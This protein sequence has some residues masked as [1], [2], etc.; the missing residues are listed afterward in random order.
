MVINTDARSAKAWWKA[1]ATTSLLA[2]GL[3]SF[4]SPTWAQ[5][6]VRFAT[7][8]PETSPLI[9]EVYRPWAEEINEAADGEFEIQILGP[10]FANTANVVDRVVTGVAEMGI[11]VLPATGQPFPRSTVTTLPLV[12]GDPARAS[13][14]LWKLQEKGLLGD[15]F[16][17]GK[18]LLFG[19]LASNTLR[20]REPITSLESLAGL[21]VRVSDKNTA[22]AMSAL[23]ASPAFISPTEMYQAASRGVVDAV[24][25]SPDTFQSFRLTELLHQHLVNVTFGGVPTAVVINK[26]FYEGLSPKGRAVLDSFTGE[27]GTRRLGQAYADFIDG[28]TASSANEPQ[29]S[30][31]RFDEAELEKVRDLISPVIESWIER[32]PDGQTVLDAFKAE[33]AAA[34]D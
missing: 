32:T 31:S 29:Y 6:V 7:T 1:K 24:I 18:L 26:S 8:L 28:I 27:D 33:Y 2:L 9:E 11:W 17:E 3:A 34:S 12:G 19:V 4:G 21:K 25:T 15:E 13:L 16:A 10:T 22:D 20:A 14:A 30:A 5:T 23:G